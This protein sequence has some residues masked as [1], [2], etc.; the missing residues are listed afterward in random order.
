MIALRH[1]AVYAWVLI[2]PA[3][4]GADLS[5]IQRAIAREPAY[6]TKPRYGLLVF[7]PE[8]K[9][10]VWLVQDGDVLTSIAVRTAT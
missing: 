5:Q 7:G 9:T 1:I 10:R 3:A 6:L 8:A 2:G 4:F